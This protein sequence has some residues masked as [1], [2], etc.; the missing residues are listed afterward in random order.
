MLTKHIYIYVDI[1]R[2]KYS[3]ERDLKRW[4]LKTTV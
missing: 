2:C 3:E 4:I 1:D